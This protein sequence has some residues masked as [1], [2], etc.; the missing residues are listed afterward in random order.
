MPISAILIELPENKTL[1]VTDA[2]N[3]MGNVEITATGA[4]RLVAVTDTVDSKTDYAIIES[5]Q[6]LEGVVNTSV[7][8]NAS[9]EAIATIEI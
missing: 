4:G 2:I 5:I 3:Q 9:D 7:V 6:S 1:E 8:F